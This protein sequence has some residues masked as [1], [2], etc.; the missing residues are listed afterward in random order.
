MAVFFTSDLH[1]GHG[2]INELSG[3]PFLSALHSEL[4]L[5]QNINSRCKPDD[6]LYHVGDFILNDALGT[7]EGYKRNVKDIENDINCKVIHILGN[8]DKKNGV[9]IGLKGCYIELAKNLLAWV[10]HYPPFHEKSLEVPP[11]DVYL[12]GHVHE[13][14][15]WVWHN[16]IPVVNVGCDVW[17]FNPV[18]KCE[19]ITFVNRLTGGK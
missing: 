10:Q 1:F 7:E 8:H 16:N 19:L 18:K 11:A 4:T 15:K 6:T 2:N 14:W 9:K 17:N 3:R 5:I 13:K 12:C